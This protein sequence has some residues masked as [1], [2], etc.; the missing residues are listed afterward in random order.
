MKVFFAVKS[1]WPCSGG[2][3]SV[4]K[5]MAEGLA[6]KGYEVIVI[7][8]SIGDNS[9]LDEHNDVK[10]IRFFHK[11]FFKLNLG[12]KRGY[13]NYIV[14]NLTEKDIFITVCA[15]SFVSE[16]FFPIIDKISARK[17]M[18]MHGM[19]EKKVDKKRVYSI[20]SFFKEF[21]LTQWW[22]YY[23]R[24]N[25]KFILKYDAYIHLF[26]ND[27][28]YS[29]FHEKKVKN[30]FVIEN[31]C[32]KIFF[33]GEANLEILDKYQIQNPYFVSVANYDD[34]KNQKLALNAFINA[35][36]Y[37]TDIVFIGA[38]KNRFSKMLEKISEKQKQ[39]NGC[40]IHIMYA[41]PRYDTV[42]LIKNSFCCLLSS[43][44]EYLPISLLEGMAC[45]KPFI[46]TAVGD[47]PKLPGGYVVDSQQ[48][49]TYWIEYYT[50][51]PDFAK[52][53]G[54]EAML[55]AKNNLYLDNKISK[56]EKIIL[57]SL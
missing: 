3:Q 32:D 19:R 24:K 49:M 35:D 40:N 14:N 13:Q 47:V 18:Y 38:R 29:Y 46:S 8:E 17:I 27:S 11:A 10:I 55:F 39:G 5:Y 30:N 37:N 26:K 20:K 45:G 21:I 34:N 1:Y 53:L 22:N 9:N 41:V 44:S 56:L 25:W 31:S 51:N 52:R 54:D 7:T 33:N 16:W 12:D 28:S 6:R 50:N 4:T 15:Q 36:I 48:E 43:H 57:N 2:I 42:Q 23:F